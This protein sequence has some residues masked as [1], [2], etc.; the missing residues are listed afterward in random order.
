MFCDA[1]LEETARGSGVSEVIRAGEELDRVLAGAS[2]R[3]VDPNDPPGG[4]MIYTS[5]AT[6]RPKGVKRFRPPTL[7]ESVATM[8]QSAAGFGLDGRGAHLVTGPLYHAAPLLF[9]IYDQANGASLVIMPRWDAMQALELIQARG[10]THTHMVPTMFV[11][12]L[13]LP[14]DVR[15]RF[16]APQLDLVLHGAAPIPIGVKREMIAWWGEKL[17]EY[18]GGSEAGLHTMVGSAEW[19][20]HPG[21]VGK[22]STSYEVFAVNDAGQRLPAG[23]IGNLY[24]RHKRLTEVFEYHGA[25]EKTAEAYL[26]P[27]VFTL[28]DIGRV[29]EDGYVYLADRKSNMIISGGVNIYPAEIE[30][31]L[32]EHPAIADV[33]VFGIPDDEWG[34]SIKAAIELV[35]GQAPSPE[36]ETQI[37]DFCRERLARYKVPRSID[38][39][40]ALPRYSNGKLYIQQLRDRYWKDRSR[41]I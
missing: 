33:G 1:R 3:S 34:E 21:T 2:N 32:Q 11:R 6:G 31:V 26:A 18:W 19:L 28:G 23:E 29:D 25:P 22:A 27:G 10:I 8:R 36:L 17:V 38:F 4:S 5:G 40:D 16:H 12:L 30:N 41:K 13:H 24:C 20:A 39:E 7:S 15:E 37:L 14:K 35:E 9:A